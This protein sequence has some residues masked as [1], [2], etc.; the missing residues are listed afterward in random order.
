MLQIQTKL[1]QDGFQPANLVAELDKVHCPESVPVVLCICVT[2]LGAGLNSCVLAQPSRVLT[3]TSWSETIAAEFTLQDTGLL[4]RRMDEAKWYKW[5]CQEEKDQFTGALA[6]TRTVFAVRPKL[7][8]IIPLPAI[9]REVVGPE[10]YDG[11]IS[12]QRNRDASTTSS[13]ICTLDSVF[14]APR[15][16]PAVSPPD[17]FRDLADE[18]TMA[19]AVKM[20]ADERKFTDQER[21]DDIAS[22]QKNRIRTV[23]DLRV[24]E[25]SD[26]KDLGFSPVITRYLLRIQS[27]RM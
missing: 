8:V 6:Q 19:E 27:G 21:D 13:V 3:L 4:W 17:K 15:S 14:S 9:V 22:L 23:G 24:L 7:E 16:L 11:L 25:P 20:V 26:I 10:L 5:P 2:S 12:A 1:W 18:V